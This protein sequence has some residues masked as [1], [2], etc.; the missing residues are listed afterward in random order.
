VRGHSVHSVGALQADTVSAITKHT[1]I[2]Q[3]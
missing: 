2:L 1:L 3:M